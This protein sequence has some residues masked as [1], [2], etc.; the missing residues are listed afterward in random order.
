M[1]GLR[2]SALVFVLIAALPLALFA[3]EPLVAPRASAAPVI[4]GK[5]DD[6]AWKTALK[7]TDFKTYKPDYDKE[8]SQKTEAYFLYDAE[9]FY[10]AFRCY[11]TDP[12][13]IKANISKR[14]G[15]FEDDC[16]ALCLDTFSDA[17]NAYLLFVNPLGIQG[18]G[19]MNS[20]GNMQPDMDFVWYSKGQ[21]DDG[22][23]SVECRIPL[24][25]IRFAGRK[26]VIMGMAFVRQIIR[27]SENSSFPAIYP[28][29][30]SLISQLQPVSISGLKYDRVVEIL[31]ALT[32]SDHSIM[33]E[34]R[35]HRDLRQTDFSLTAKVGLTS[36]LT[37]DATYNPDFSQVESDAGQVDFNV[38]YSLYYPEKRPFFME[39]LEY[40]QVAGNPE[41]SPLRA[42]VYTRTIINPILGFKA[43]GKL[44][45]KN[46][47]A[48][49]Y[50]HDDLPGDP[51]DRYP[52][53]GIV[54]FRHSLKD[55]SFIGGFYTSRF[56]GSGFNQVAGTDGRF[57]L[58]GASVA[59]YNLFGS[60]T[61]NPGAEATVNGH[62]LSLYY[63]YGTRSVYAEVSG[64]DISKYF[65]VDTGF[66]TRTGI[67]RLAPFFMYKFYPK[68][69][70]FQ[71]IEPFYWG[72]HIYDKFYGTFET[73]NVLAL[74]F[75]LPRSSMFRVDGLLGNEVYVGRKFNRD[76]YRFMFQTQLSKHLYLEGMFRRGGMIFYDPADPYQGYG[77][78]AQANA[79]YQP[80]EKFS[81]GLSYTYVGFYRESDSQKVYDYGI[82]RS[83]NTFQVNKYLFLRAIFEYNTFYRRLTTD[84]LISF[85]YIPG[86]V[87]HVGYGSAYE[88]LAWT[89]GELVD[90]NRFLETQRG[91]FFKVSYLW[92]W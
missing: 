53:F 78:Q 67:S 83:R 41:E 79:E 11:D 17:Q 65:Q 57:R 8:P 10:F 27:A 3:L 13:L 74:R 76:S 16:V 88:K 7:F 2:I 31:P 55:D 43:T 62:A 22:G 37:S 84:G 33:N 64:Q 85:T 51:V 24:Q 46:T 21:I 6:D 44:G 54:R 56:Q 28:D 59:E 58:T 18:D 30:G 19:L 34:G 15:M 70:I 61:R 72:E 89:G 14:D 50:A 71:R 23:Y 73:Y 60:F 81:F 87:V 77:N 48:S 25:S 82:I 12:G 63:N 90:S 86:T 32:H 52:D 9:N 42:V 75:W 5:L 69:S 4:D 66:V 92:R 49:I 91:F 47:I 36:D 39:G 35:L 29:K 20:I 38:R 80:L 68:S 40:F 1:S 26:T 45:T